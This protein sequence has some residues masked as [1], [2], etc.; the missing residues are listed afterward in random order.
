MLSEGVPAS[1]APELTSGFSPARARL[2]PQAGR[3][4]E[5]RDGPGSRG[6]CGHALAELPSLLPLENAVSVSSR[7]VKLLV[8]NC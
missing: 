1:A 3:D 4:A 2:R 7:Y 8:Y 5:D 6:T